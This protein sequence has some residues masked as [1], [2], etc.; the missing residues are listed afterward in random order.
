MDADTFR[1]VLA[2]V[3]PHVTE[4]SLHLMGEPLGHESF[5]VYVA[6]CDERGLRINLTTNGMLLFGAK[7]KAALHPA[8][9][10]VNISVQSFAANFPGQKPDAYLQRVFAFLAQ[11]QEQRPDLYVNLRVWDRHEPDAESAENQLLVQKI[12]QHFGHDK[13]P[14]LDVRRRKNAPLGGRISLHF[15]SRFI[16]PDLAQPVRSTQ[17]FCYGASRQLG[18]HADGTVVP[19][20]LDKD[21]S[22]KLGSLKEQS[23]AEIVDGPRAK[24]MR[25][26]FSRGELVEDLCQRCD[27]IKRFD[28]KK[29]VK[30][31]Q[32]PAE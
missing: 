11:A 22:V 29:M 3:S 1:R 5:A 24:A 32:K 12:L 14:E 2:E 8:V 17:G 13:M 23:F 16:W 19:C 18:V 20:C 31:T 27:F 30:A 25:E 6:L 15:D 28:R 9:R 10:Q 21:A 4:V 7:A 26:G